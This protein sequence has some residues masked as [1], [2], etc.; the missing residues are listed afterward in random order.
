MAKSHR[1]AKQAPAPET[2][3]AAAATDATA[4]S[5]S[6]LPRA[7]KPR[8][9]V[10]PYA[11]L[12]RLDHEA[13]HRLD[14]ASQYLRLLS[15]RAYAFERRLPSPADAISANESE[16][17][18]HA[19]DT[20]RKHGRTLGNA[21]GLVEQKW[22]HAYRA[23]ELIDTCLAVSVEIRAKLDEAEKQPKGELNSRKIYALRQALTFLDYMECPKCAALLDESQP[24]PAPTWPTRSWQAPPCQCSR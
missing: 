14:G 20:T 18:A 24:L 17:R 9:S 8:A 23:I 19:K 21:A 2:D 16:A 11:Q 5:L 3:S 10:S 22:R 1:N 15:N 6:P 12:V 7:P 4:Q 13:T